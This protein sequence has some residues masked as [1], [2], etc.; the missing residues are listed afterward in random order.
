MDRD[1]FNKVIEYLSPSL[2]LSY[3]FIHQIIFVLIGIILSFYLINKNFINSSIRS[4]NNK[5]LDKKVYRGL[6]KN[7]K[8]INISSNRIKDIKDE[9]KHTLVEAIEELGFI[10]SIEENN[11]GGAA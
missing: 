1:S 8:V 9:S 10:P 6:I 4:I 7:D 11:N 3:F 2:V 5:L